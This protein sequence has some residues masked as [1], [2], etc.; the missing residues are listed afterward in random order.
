MRFV[1]SL[2]FLILIVINLVSVQSTDTPTIEPTV[3]LEPTIEPTF[4]PTSTP[5]IV[6]TLKP[7]STPTY[8]PSSKPTFTPTSSPTRLADI[9]LF[10]IPFPPFSSSYKTI[11]SY[12]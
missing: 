9:K 8:T 7:S 10:L 1:F 4:V 2:S 11:Y 5:T 12:I 6:P 3:S